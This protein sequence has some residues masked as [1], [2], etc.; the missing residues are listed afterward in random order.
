VANDQDTPAEFFPTT[1]FN[2]ATFAAATTP[3][4]DIAPMADSSSCMTQ[5][6]GV[7][8][9]CA[10]QKHCARIVA[11]SADLAAPGL[12]FSPADR[13]ALWRLNITAVVHSAA[14]VDH[15]RPYERYF[16]FYSPVSF[17]SIHFSFYDVPLLP[18]FQDTPLSALRM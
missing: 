15:A 18:P 16:S 2:E 17:V 1:S 4:S 12:G 5:N 6:C 7:G 9:E 14:I 8:H 10:R 13:D 3:F 11:F